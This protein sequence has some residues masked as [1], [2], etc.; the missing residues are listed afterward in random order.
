[1]TDLM[2]R[3][4]LFPHEERSEQAL[5]IA[6]S[7]IQSNLNYMMQNTRAHATFIVTIL[8]LASASTASARQ[9]PKHKAHVRE[10]Y[11]A[12]EQVDW[13]Y[14]P[15]GLELMHGEDVP[16]PWGLHRQWKKTRFIEYTDGTFSRRKP[17][18]DWLGILG[19]IIRAEVG[20][21]VVV[22]FR[23]LAQ[24]YHSIHVHGL[25][26]DKQNE[27]AVYSSNVPGIA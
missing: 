11:I 6:Q 2:P 23:N 10:Y 18:P 9:K 5:V 27:G 20:D 1:M 13:D 14:F 17:Q 3:L 21:A 8:L 16:F 19:P 25:R 7:P 4:L 15:S 22:H 26:Y 24:G 12:A